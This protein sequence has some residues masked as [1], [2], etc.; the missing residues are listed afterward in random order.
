MSKI[1]NKFKKHVNF[2]HTE[3][4]T[5]EPKNIGFHTDSR[6]NLHD[7]NNYITHNGTIF[8]FRFENCRFIR[9][10]ERYTKT[11]R[12]ARQVKTY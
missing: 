6:Q 8:T 7:H 1:M 2:K 3:L 10:F 12:T 11:T 9:I 4:F 5:H